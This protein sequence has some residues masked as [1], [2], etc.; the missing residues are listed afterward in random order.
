MEKLRPQ[1]ITRYVKENIGTFHEKRIQSLDGLKLAGVLKRKNPYLFKAK[2]MMTAEQIIKGLTDAH[3]SSNEETIFGD[4]LEGLA[5][6]INGKT[7][8]G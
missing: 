8:G 5:V 2:Y 4:W 1:D 7:F 6:F 3:I